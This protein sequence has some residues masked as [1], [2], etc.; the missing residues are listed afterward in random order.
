MDGGAFTKQGILVYNGNDRALL[1]LDNATNSTNSNIGHLVIVNA[2]DIHRTVC[3][4]DD[5]NIST[6][7][8]TIGTT[9]HKGMGQRRLVGRDVVDCRPHLLHSQTADAWRTWT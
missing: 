9:I 8:T 4:V 2:T 6:C 1:C 5:P 3:F 7:Q